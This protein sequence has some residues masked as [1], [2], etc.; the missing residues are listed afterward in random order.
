MVETRNR[1]VPMLTQYHQYG[2]STDMDCEEGQN[3]LLALDM[4]STVLTD[5]KNFGYTPNRK[6]HITKVR[7]TYY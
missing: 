2:S 4:N 6:V 5:R 3:S 1:V 7:K